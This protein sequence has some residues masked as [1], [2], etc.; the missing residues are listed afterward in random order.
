MQNMKIAVFHNLP[1]G[2]AKRALY[3]FVIYLKSQGNTID[4][5]VPS[6]ANENFLPLSN[7]VNNITIFPVQETILGKLISSIK[8]IPPLLKYISF[9]DLENTEKQIAEAVNSGDYDI[10]LSEQDQCT[11]APFFL[12]YIKK[13]TVYYCQ[14]PLRNDAILEIVSQ[15][16]KKIN[17]IKKLLKK[18]FEQYKRF[19]IEKNNITHSTYIL[20]NSYFSRESLLRSYGYNSFVSYLGIDQNLFK[21]LEIPEENFVLSVGTCT[22]SKGYDFIIRSLSLINKEIKPNFII[23]SNSKDE[24]WE[25]YLNELAEKLEVNLEIL[26]SIT[27]EKLVELY[28]KAKLVVYAPYLEP[29]GL[30]PLEAMGCGTPVVGIKEGGMRETVIDDETGILTDRDEPLFANAIVEL[31]LNKNKRQRMSKKGIITIQNFWTLEDSG[32]R[33]L[34]HLNRVINKQ[35]LRIN[36]RN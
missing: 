15:A 25:K 33:L 26:S 19:K 3:N 17:P 13:P 36:E 2:G 22:P 7:L 9:K 21:P 6:T 14:Q 5:F 20:T 31:L 30:V 34:K 12:K 24:I 16:P 18:Y 27:D 8:Y 28:N 11:M 29:F 23:V 4:V 32:K 35:G 10:V 1:S